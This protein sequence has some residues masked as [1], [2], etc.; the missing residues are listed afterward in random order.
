MEGV[1]ELSGKEA[2]WRKWHDVGLCS[3]YS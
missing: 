2:E 3:L 1:L